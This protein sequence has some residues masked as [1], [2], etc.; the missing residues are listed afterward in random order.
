MTSAGTGGPIPPAGWPPAAPVESKG[1]PKKR[2]RPKA[3]VKADTAPADDA[4]PPRLMTPI[5]PPP[6]LAPSWQLALFDATGVA[7]AR[8]DYA[9]PLPVTPAARNPK[10]PLVVVSGDEA[11]VLDPVRGDPVRRVRLPDD[12]LPG[13]VFS[14]VVDGAPVVGVLLANPLRVL[15]F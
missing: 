15:L 4:L 7:V 6:G 1:Q 5:A 9:L 8:N 3:K 12:A 10:A 14:T 11:L 2:P 13:T